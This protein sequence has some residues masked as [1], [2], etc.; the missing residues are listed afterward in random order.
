ME[1]SEEKAPKNLAHS[2]QTSKRRGT[3][4][5]MEKIEF[6]FRKEQSGIFGNILRPVA[7]VF[8]INDKIRIPEILYV[9]SGADVT[10]I[11]KSVGELL[12]LKLTQKDSVEEIKGIGERSVA[13]IIKKIQIQIGD[14]VIPSRISWALTE[15]VPLLLGRIDVFHLF[16]ITFAKSKKTIFTK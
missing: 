11:S 16:D 1:R 13:M 9:D 15:E 10:L 2:S 14:T 8:L 7:R 3:R 12:G 6:A 5:S 4:S